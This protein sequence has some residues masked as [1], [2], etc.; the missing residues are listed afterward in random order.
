MKNRMAFTP[1]RSFL[2]NGCIG[3]IHGDRVRAEGQHV[4]LSEVWRAWAGASDSQFF[5]WFVFR[6]RRAEVAAMPTLMEDWI[7]FQ[8]GAWELDARARATLRWN[9]PL[10]RAKPTMQIVIGGTASQP[11]T[12]A[13]GIGIG[14][15]RVLSIRS[16]LL[17]HGIDP[18]RIGIAIRGTGWSLSEGPGDTETPMSSRYSE[19]RLQVTDPHWMVARN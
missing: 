12:T 9:V 8:E 13:H 19:C 4:G 11:G 6:P 14:L 18:A 3:A 17:A 5:N 1:W 15:R 7:Y 10:I 2:G 16:F